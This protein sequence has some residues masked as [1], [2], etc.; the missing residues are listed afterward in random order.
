MQKTAP[1]PPSLIPGGRC[2]VK[3]N[4]GPGFGKSHTS[5]MSNINND[6]SADLVSLEIPAVAFATKHNILSDVCERTVS[7]AAAVLISHRPH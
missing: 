1:Y 3:R 6:E 4:G 5:E 2:R 7:H